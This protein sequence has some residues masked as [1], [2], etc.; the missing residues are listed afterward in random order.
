MADKG[1]VVIGITSAD[2]WGNTLES[3][4]RFLTER[5]S[6]MQYRAAW[7]PPSTGADSL[8]GIFNHP[9]MQRA[10]TQS[11]PMAFLVNQEG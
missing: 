11:L 6:L 10:E 7:V 8:Q 9:W 5:D 3:V 1:L 2:A 4:E